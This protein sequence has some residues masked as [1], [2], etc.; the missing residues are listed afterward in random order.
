VETPAP[1]VWLFDPG[2][3]DPA[4]LLEAI[5]QRIQRID[6]EGELAVGACVYQL[7]EFVAVAR[8]RLEDRENEQLRGA[9]LQFAIE[10][11]AVDICHGQIVSEQAPMW[12]LF[13]LNE[14]AI[15]LVRSLH[16]R[17]PF[18]QAV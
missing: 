4:T 5:E 7:A 18:E 14:F 9:A 12:C 17:S 10:R 11:A 3:F 15:L 1:L 6:V 2:A 13:F 16:G 8:P